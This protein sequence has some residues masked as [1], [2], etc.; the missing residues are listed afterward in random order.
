M[1]KKYNVLKEYKILF[2]KYNRLISCILNR[3]PE[4]LRKFYYGNY[5]RSFLGLTYRLY[6]LLS[7]FKY[8]NI[9][10]KPD[11]RRRFDYNDYWHTRGWGYRD[12]TRRSLRIFR[13]LGYIEY[14]GDDYCTM[15][16]IISDN[17][18]EFFQLLDNALA[19][20][21]LNNS[22]WEHMRAAISH[23]YYSVD[24]W[25]EYKNLT[26]KSPFHFSFKR[27]Q[28]EMNKYRDYCLKNNIVSFYRIGEF[29]RL[30]G[31]MIMYDDALDGIS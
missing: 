5:I 13:E 9:G 6:G 18:W 17:E 26:F 30:K 7:C 3:S 27:W 25:D 14:D 10:T 2:V 22:N 11:N 8:K 31:T 29:H 24:D 16:S 20:K 23:L 15:E 28:K 19:D 4:E 12:I 1:K 21:I